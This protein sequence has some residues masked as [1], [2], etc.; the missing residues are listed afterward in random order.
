M[1]LGEGGL[2]RYDGPMTSGEFPGTWTYSH[3]ILYHSL[4][5]RGKLHH[6]LTYMYNVIHAW[7]LMKRPMA[8]SQTTMIFA[9]VRDYSSL[10][11][12]LMVRWIG[13]SHDI[14]WSC[15]VTVAFFPPCGALE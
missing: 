3:F 15:C 11:Y 7:L 4:N 2:S 14:Y 1:V 8:D 9:G 13:M 6:I 12:P 5:L 10:L